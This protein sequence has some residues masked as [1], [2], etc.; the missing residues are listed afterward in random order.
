MFVP[1][2]TYIDG[3]A[4]CD[5]VDLTHMAN[6]VSSCVAAARDCFLF[7]MEIP[8]PSPENGAV[9]SE[10]MNLTQSANFTVSFSSSFIFGCVST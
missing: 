1:Y 4:L 2:I 7:S 3:R 10:M 5:P 8:D 9:T 6:P